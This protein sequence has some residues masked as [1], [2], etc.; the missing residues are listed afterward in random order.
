MKMNQRFRELLISS[1][2]FLIA[3]LPFLFFSVV[4]LLKD[5][6]IWPDEPVFFDAARNFIESGLI[7]TDI[8]G[9]LAPYLQDNVYAYPP[10]YFYTLGAWIKIFGED[11]E[12]LR[13][14]SVILGMGVLGIFFYLSYKLT[15]SKF[16]STLATLYLSMDYNFSR[17]TRLVR[18][19]VLALIFFLASFLFLLLAYDKR[20]KLFFLLSGLFSGLSLLTHPMGIVAPAVLGVS[21]LLWP[22]KV[23]EKIKII[24]FVGFPIAIEI[25][26]W[27]LSI[28]NSLSSIIGQLQ[29]QIIRKNELST[30]L[31]ISFEQDFRLF[32][33]F[34]I[35]LCI[36]TLFSYQIFKNKESFK[37]NFRQLLILIGFLISFV[38]VILGKEMWYLVYFS[39]FTV[40]ASALL[41]KS[42]SKNSYIW[43]LVA[44]SFLLNISLTITN[45]TKTMDLDY[46]EFTK[47]ISQYIPDGKH[48]CLTT[49]PDPYFDL[50]KNKSLKLY[51]F[52][53]TSSQ[54]IDR[55]GFLDNCEF[56][57]INYPPDKFT[58]DYIEANK[59]SIIQV[60][61]GYQT[62]IIELEDN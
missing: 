56:L 22:T 53:Y 37:R 11:I 59:K 52:L 14:L 5:P 23:K 43:I 26:I 60:N 2:V 32:L 9:K 12:V 54:S 8:H 29:Y 6:S 21:I 15:Q 48:V 28:K 55:K 35:N 34:V 30:Y 7:T 17:S 46:H 36:L 13:R 51:E 33:I 3:L 58:L 4:L 62:N 47:E 39:P 31:F 42:F 24:A 45:L 57:I 25:L 18:M 49:I 40:L 27:F 61:K 41:L 50:Q 16:F 20:K 1:E 44:A 10:L 19:E 38:L